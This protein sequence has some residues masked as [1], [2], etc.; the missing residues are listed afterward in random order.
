MNNNSTLDQLLDSLGY[1]EWITLTSSFIIPTISL[2]GIFIC[3]MSG[4]I[5]F[6]PR[7]V[8]PVF[9]YYRLLCFV[10]IIQL[11]HGIPYG[12]LFSPRYLPRINSYACSLYHIY[13]AVVST[14]LF[15]FNEMLQM[16][17]LLDRMKLFSP[18]L[19]RHFA[20]TPR[21]VSLFLFLTCLFI[22]STFVFSFKI[23]SAK[24]HIG[25][26]YFI[27]PSDV[28]STLYGQILLGFTQMFLNRFLTLVLGVALNVLSFYKYKSYLKERKREMYVY[29]MGSIHFKHVRQKEIRLLSRIERV[30]SQIEKNMFYMALSACSMS[31]FLRIL[32][33]FCFVSFFFCIS[34]TYTPLVGLIYYSIHTLEP[35]FNVCVFFTFNKMFRNKFKRKLSFRR[36]CK[37]I[38]KK[39]CEKQSRFFLF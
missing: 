32:F 5:F 26:F 36:K 7:F 8:N 22:D 14:F 25:T 3:S 23:N 17:I 27:N 19:M 37:V 38:I 30:K 29:S 35:I 2:M 24:Y 20:Y 18:F 15:H 31:I 4:L 11:A 33:M 1:Y 9:Y 13:Y 34:I 21:Q 10:Y 6:Q 39:Q 28:S 12:L 16:A